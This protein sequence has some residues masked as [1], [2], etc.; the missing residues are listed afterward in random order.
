MKSDMKE[1]LMVN[2]ING[3]VLAVS[4]SDVESVLRIGL[5]AATIVYTIV[6]IVSAI[7]RQEEDDDTKSK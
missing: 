2:G 5:L 4:F 7:N 1:L 6:K 3:V